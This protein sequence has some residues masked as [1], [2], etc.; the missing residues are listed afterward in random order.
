MLGD[1]NSELICSYVALRDDVDAVIEVARG[2]KWDEDTYYSVRSAL[3]TDLDLA[4]RGARFIFLN[5]TGWNGLYR[6]NQQGEYNVPMGTSKTNG[7]WLDEAAL[8][9]ASSVL[10]NKEIVAC[11]YEILC[12]QGRPGDFYYLD[13]PYHGDASFTK[14]TQL[15]FTH[16]DHE[17]LADIA[18]ELRDRG[19]LVIVTN[20]NTP[21]IQQLYSDRDFSL[22]DSWSSRSL[23]SNPG[24]RGR[25][26]ELLITSW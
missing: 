4:E 14:Y 15:D 21:Y 13:P 1:L 7:R 26:A 22:H 11:N 16:V 3:T 9:A 23:N 2:W 5:R 19:C 10:Q 25:R 24:L 17:R 8:R 12:E 20:S 18:A 6:V